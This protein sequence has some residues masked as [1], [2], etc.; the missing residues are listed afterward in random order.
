MSLSKPE[1]F[2]AAQGTAHFLL[3]FK[4]S[5]L[6]GGLYRIFEFQAIWSYLLFADAGLR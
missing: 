1:E 5:H 3:S 6:P 2:G 4:P